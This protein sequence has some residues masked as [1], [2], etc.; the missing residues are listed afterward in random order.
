MHKKSLARAVLAGLAE[1]LAPTANA[2]S[3]D[4]EQDCPYEAALEHLYRLW[5]AE[6]ENSRR[7]AAKTRL[8]L[9]GTIAF[10]AAGLFRFGLQALE[11]DLY[12][13][14]PVIEFAAITF[15]LLAFTFFL[16]SS[17]YLIFKKRGEAEERIGETLAEKRIV[18]SSRLLFPSEEFLD[19]L[20]EPE[21]G[22]AEH[23][24]YQAFLVTLNAAKDL[25]S[26][27]AEKEARL[28]LSGKAFFIG[29]FL[30]SLA[31]SLYLAGY[32]AKETGEPP[33]IKPPEGLVVAH[34]GEIN[35][36]ER[37]GRHTTAESP[38]HG[39][40]TSEPRGSSK[41]DSQLQREDRDVD[42]GEEPPGL[43]DEPGG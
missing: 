30:F 11:T 26:Q 4:Q 28:H 1:Y 34:E 24:R 8:V 20:R 32:T 19:G 27:N 5:N 35:A 17:R 37:K 38:E 3:G 39:E 29:L 23:V 13:Q 2:E 16:L 14:H 25:A 10:L 36:A 22:S 12:P 18:S 40:V 21:P 31:V 33:G 15:L 42:G 9:T 43:D 7:Y 6:E 41:V